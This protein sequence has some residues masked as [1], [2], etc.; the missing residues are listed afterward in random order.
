MSICPP[1]RETPI[2]S[3]FFTCGSTSS[4]CTSTNHFLAPLQ[5]LSCNN[6]S[7]PYYTLRLYL[8]IVQ[9]VDH[10]TPPCWRPRWLHSSSTLRLLHGEITGVGLWADIRHVRGAAVESAA[11]QDTRGVGGGTPYVSRQAYAVDLSRCG[12][13]VGF[14]WRGVCGVDNRF[15]GSGSFVLLHCFEAWGWRSWGRVM[16]N[17]WCGWG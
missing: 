17:T 9:D 2:T 15:D 7:N 13:C 11:L 16:A 6:H 5:L 3:G 10:P 8:S 14:A 12:Y 4:T 1:K